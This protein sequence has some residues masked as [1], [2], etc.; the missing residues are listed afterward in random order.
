M[1]M[2]FSGTSA[3]NVVISL[4]YELL[5]GVRDHPTRESY[6]ANALGGRQAIPAMLDLFHRRNISAT[7]ATVGALLCENSLPDQPNGPAWRPAVVARRP[8]PVPFGAVS[9]RLATVLRPGR[10]G[11]W[12]MRCY[13][14]SMVNMP[15]W[16]IPRRRRRVVRGVRSGSGAKWG[17]TSIW[18]I[19]CA[20]RVPC[21]GRS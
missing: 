7:W 18:S 4:G 13:D 14:I 17:R 9:M 12:C 2:R 15:G 8:S 19:S 3:G 6:G 10:M 11:D 5:W 20:I 16:W 1:A 21:L